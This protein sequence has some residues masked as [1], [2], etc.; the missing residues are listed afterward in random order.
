MA[1]VTL[2]NGAAVRVGPLKWQ[3][4]KALKGKVMDLLAERVVQ[5]F[6]AGNGTFEPAHAASLVRDLPAVVDSLNEEFVAGCVDKPALL[7][8][9]TLDVND[10]DQLY[11][12]AL[13]IN[14]IEGIL[15]REKNSPAG[16]LASKLL[17]LMP[18]GKMRLPGAGG[19]SPSLNVF[20]PAGES[21][22]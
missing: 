18:A 16:E 17:D 5:L 13:Q 15:A 3:A 2:S 1:G 7:Q 6:A 11:R 21:Q 9:E 14:P 8:D 22:S 12:E 4:Y 19:S 10:F 20:D